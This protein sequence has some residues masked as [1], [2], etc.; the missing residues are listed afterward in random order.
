MEQSLQLKRE[1]YIESLSRA[2]SAEMK[3]M[4]TQEREVQIH[5]LPSKLLARQ[6]MIQT[7]LNSSTHDLAFRRQIIPQ[8]RGATKTVVYGN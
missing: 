8:T 6:L 1:K 4:A 3:S 5:Q 7:Q 2:I